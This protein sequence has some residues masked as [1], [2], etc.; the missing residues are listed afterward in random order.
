VTVGEAFETA[1]T[2]G[3]ERRRDVAVRTVSF[4]VPSAA[5]PAARRLSPAS[6]AHFDRGVEIVSKPRPQYTD[7]ARHLR[8]EGEVV[9]AVLFNSD[10]RVHVKRIL[11]GLGHGLDERAVEAALQISFLPARHDGKAVDVV[12]TVRIQFQLA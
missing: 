2:S 4:G 3:P 6:P 11:R 5:P 1:Q 9:L 8:V 10:G 12:A 7:E